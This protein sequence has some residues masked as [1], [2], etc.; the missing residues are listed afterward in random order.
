MIKKVIIGIL[1]VIV[2]L[3]VF[4]NAVIKVFA[5]K[6]TSSITGLELKINH[7]D[8][9]LTK[10]FVDIEGLKIFNPK[11]F[12]DRVMLDLPETY[13]DYN[14]GDFFKGKI[15][16]EDIRINLSEFAVIKNKNGELNIDSLKVVQDEKQKDTPT[17]KA[18]KKQGEAPSI[19]I[20]YLRLRIGKVIYKDYSKGGE[21]TV[22][23]FSLNI[24][25]E[26]E[27]LNNPGDLVKVIVAE[28]LLNT[29]IAKLTNFDIANLSGSVSG[30]LDSSKDIAGEA[31]GKV[32][33][34]V[35]DKIDVTSGNIAGK[36]KENVEETV[37]FL[38]EKVKGFSAGLKEKLKLS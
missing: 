28:A 10:S 31:V 15:H 11:D 4:R 22:K 19:Q 29:T 34:M 21:P 3:V 25:K 26:Y 8:L 27:N 7:F 17:K 6:A 1:V 30:V 9:S 24:D 2:L 12:Q 32:Y 16:L 13:I 23:E 5:Q 20:D 33:G 38:G 36:A 37:G 14:I 35:E 18:E